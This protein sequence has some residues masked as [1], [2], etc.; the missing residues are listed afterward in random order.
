MVLKVARLL[1]GVSHWCGTVS[2]YLIFALTGVMV[3]EVLMRYFF[4][5]PTFFAYDM[6][7]MLFGGYIALGAGYCHL[8]KSHV[9]IDFFYNQ[10]SRPKQTILEIILSAIFFFPLLTLIII[11]L[12][13]NVIYSWE[14][15]ERAS[16]SI[17]RPPVYPFKSIVLLG[18]IVLFLQGLSELIKNIYIAVK[19]NPDEH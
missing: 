9:R 10:L 7:W 17:W 11:Y 6:S 4:R 12:T 1:D 3:I 5:S 2:G 16:A 19:G 8:H 15:G 13:D 14:S 18:F